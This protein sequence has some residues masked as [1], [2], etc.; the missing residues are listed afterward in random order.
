MRKAKAQLEL[1]LAKEVKGS[2]KGF[3]I[4]GRRKV[5]DGVGSLLS[6]AGDLVTGIKENA[7]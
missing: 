5:R 2:T 4:V 1:T 6:G 7:K 3:S